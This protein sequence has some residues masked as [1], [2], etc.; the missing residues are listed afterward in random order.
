MAAVE[1]P[2]MIARILLIRKFSSA[3]LPFQVRK[4][5]AT[6]PLLVRFVAADLSIAI[7]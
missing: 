3:A 6:A 7:F 5:A 1:D 2:G 4:R